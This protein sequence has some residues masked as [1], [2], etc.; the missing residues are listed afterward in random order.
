M[1]VRYI[2]QIDIPH[3][4]VDYKEYFETTPEV[5][6]R[7]PQSISGFIMQIHFPQPSVNGMLVLTQAMVLPSSPDMQS[8]VLDLDAFRAGDLVTH[9]EIWPTLDKL[10]KIKND[11]FEA[12]ITDK[13]RALFG[14]QTEG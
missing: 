1:A 13:T 5:S 3:S 14:A 9:E 2:Y 4:T 11:F 7:L 6:P 10:R 12:S 8:V